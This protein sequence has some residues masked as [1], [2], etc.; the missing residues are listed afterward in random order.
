MQSIVCPRCQERF[1]VA[2]DLAQ[3]PC[4]RCGQVVAIAETHVTAAPTVS[5]AFQSFAEKPATDAANAAI[6]L[7]ER[8]ASWEE[9][10]SMSPKIQHHMLKLATQPLPD[11]RA[12]KRL[13]LPPETPT[14]IDGW[15]QP[16]GSLKI[17]GESWFS[18]QLASVILIGI[19]LMFML[20]GA[21]PLIMEDQAPQRRDRRNPSM[22]VV[23]LVYGGFG[24][25][26]IG[27]SIWLAFFR[28]P[29]LRLTLWIFEEGLFLRRGGE[30]TVV[31]WADLQDYEVS[32]ETGRP[33]FWLTLRDEAPI[34]LSVGHCPEVI[35][36][37]EYMEIRMAG[38]QLLPR[39]K[40][41]W[42]GQRER[43]GVLTL[44]H[45]G[46]AGPGFFAPWSQVS[47]VMSDAKSL[48]VDWSA[49]TSWTAVRYRDV[50]FP[51]LVMAIAHILIDE[52]S[53]LGPVEA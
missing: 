46:I 33:L 41:I 4:V 35:P 17:G 13:P 11:L 38:A 27:L 23:A 21:L 6:E 7:P 19:G 52:H 34:V 40:A 50:S 20:M 2:D 15:A 10:R 30:S 22:T 37:M 43:F 47:R 32:R 9:F 1:D 5:Q 12:I 14:E 8:Y 42:H 51:Y 44:D 45:D 24:N 53:R 31:R 16:L 48:Y 18:N 39:L 36:L 28:R 49:R 25:V 26:F 3:A 29:R